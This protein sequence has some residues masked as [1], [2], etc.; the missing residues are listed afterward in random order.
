M[1]NP[2]QLISGFEDS[3][4][5]FARGN[6]TVGK[7]F[8]QPVMKQI[9]KQIEGCNSLQGFCFLNSF[10]GG[11][12]SGF[13]SAVQEELSII[14]GKRPKFQIGIYPSRRMATSTVYPYNAIFHTHSTMTHT[15]LN[16]LMDNEAIYDI[17]TKKLDIE[18]PTYSNINRIIVQLFSSVT[19]SVRSK[20]LINSDIDQLCTNLVPYPRIHFPLSHLSPL[21]SANKAD[22]ESSSVADMTRDIFDTENQ[23]VQCNAL[24]GRFMS[25][26]LQFRGP[27][28]PALVNKT[29]IEIKKRNDVNFVE[30]CPTGFKIGISSM[31]S[32]SPP[33]SALA[34]MKKTV[35]MLS[36]STA[37]V[38]LWVDLLK[39]F[40]LLFSRRSFIHWFVGEGL[41]EG[42]F[43]EAYQNIKS[44]EKDYL[45]ISEPE[46][47]GKLNIATS[48]SM[49]SSE[50]LSK[51]D[52]SKIN[53]K[54]ENI[55]KRMT[56]SGSD[57]GK[58]S[59]SE[60]SA[61]SGK[62]D[63]TAKSTKSSKSTL[64]SKESGSSKPK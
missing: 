44:L 19:I 4:N 58:S 2:D 54:E 43:V 51:T 5:N 15:D 63:K 23:L 41:E 32:A 11:T 57:L 7:S 47:Q 45:E 30:W 10:D 18:R 49:A 50:Y 20:N 13:T 16:I 27:I 29:I 39:K 36:N 55:E 62:T 21:L 28:P 56:K 48:R 60:K 61:K 8:L 3:A 6:F 26:V 22:K 31:P 9:R 17:C 52:A 53:Y 46:L 14:Y 37:I 1:F 40:D 59:K 25:C 38:E 12:G 64:L 34:N 35:A 24:N 42:E 33:G